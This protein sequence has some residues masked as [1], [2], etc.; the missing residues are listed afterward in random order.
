MRPAFTDYA[1]THMW[2]ELK[3]FQNVEMTI[4]IQKETINKTAILARSKIS[5]KCSGVGGEPPSD[6]RPA[7]PC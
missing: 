7:H 1:K 5:M 4:Y 2:V 3:H 6:Q